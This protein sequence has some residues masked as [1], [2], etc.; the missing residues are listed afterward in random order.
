LFKW[1]L[2]N[3]LINTAHLSLGIHLPGGEAGRAQQVPAGLNPDVFVV[4]RTYLAQLEGA[5]CNPEK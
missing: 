4:L 3:Y 2:L 1:V 5:A